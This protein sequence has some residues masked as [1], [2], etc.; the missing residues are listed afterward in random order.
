MVLNEG[1]PTHEVEKL[2]ARNARLEGHI[3]KLE[4]ELIDLRG[5]QENYGQLL[6]DV[7]VSRD[8]LELAKKRLEEVETRGAE[9]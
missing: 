2:A 3:A 6:E 1:G 4:V 5:K 8:E 7:R 9:E